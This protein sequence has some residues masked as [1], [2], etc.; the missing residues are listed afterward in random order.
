M[1]L[2]LS[3]L[4]SLGMG[5]IEEAK[6]ISEQLRQSIERASFP[7]EMRRCDHLM[8]HIALAE[9]RPDE[10]VHFFEHA[11]SLLP[12]QRV[13]L[14]EQAFYKNSLAAAYYQNGTWSRALEAYQG[15]VSLTTG[16]LQWGDIYARSTY[17]LAKI[18][19]RTDNRAAAVAHF[20][21]FLELWK[22]ADPRLPEVED[23]KKQL[24]NLKKA[25]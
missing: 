23:A 9:G 11:V 25:P 4:A 21:N 17:W 22:N 13:N 12:S 2:H 7:N 1:A 14:D 19:Q 5:Q 3:G 24:Q 20:E 6:R 18:C 10:A 15:I 16:R 8:G